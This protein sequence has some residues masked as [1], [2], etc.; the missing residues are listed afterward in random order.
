M[1]KRLKIYA[2]AEHEQSAQ[3]PQRIRFTPKGEIER[4]GD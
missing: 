3:Q 4:I 1:L 2:G